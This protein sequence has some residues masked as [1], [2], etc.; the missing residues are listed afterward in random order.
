MSASAAS[1]ST[2]RK[3]STPTAEAAIQAALSA[4]T[5]DPSSTGPPASVFLY[6]AD[7]TLSPILSTSTTTDSTSTP[8]PFPITVLSQLTSAYISIQE[9]LSRSGNPA[10]S[11]RITT[12]LTN[13]DIIIQG[14][15]LGSNAP[16]K[17]LPNPVMESLRP[18]GLRSGLSSASQT[19][20][21]VSAA[22]SLMNLSTGTGTGTGTDTDTDNET[23]N[24]SVR[25][26]RRQRQLGQSQDRA[27]PPS[28]VY[29]VY[30]CHPSAQCATNGEDSGSGSSSSTPKSL[31]ALAC[32]EVMKLEW[33]GKKWQEEWRPDLSMI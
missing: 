5:Q 21:Q 32:E 9:L 4:P 19:P 33:L 14:L 7:T 6:L 22:S 16:R 11:P 1:T 18:S 12:R 30:A 26:P 29:T 13:G 2:H 8:L 25:R 3:S 10:S 15:L 20:R 27:L 23:A 31:E 28:L 17:P 24:D